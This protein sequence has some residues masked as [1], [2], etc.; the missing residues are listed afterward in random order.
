MIVLFG[1]MLPTY[2]KQICSPLLHLIRR[3]YDESRLEDIII[4]IIKSAY[5]LMIVVGF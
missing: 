4:K 5:L 2:P 3:V 1:I